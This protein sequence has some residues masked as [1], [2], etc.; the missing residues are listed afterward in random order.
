MRG[1]NTFV[2]SN[3]ARPTMMQG[4]TDFSKGTL[5]EEQ[6]GGD[7]FALFGA[8]FKEAETAGM[9]E[10][11][12]MALATAGTV[13]ISC[14]IVY[15]RGFDERGF[16][17]FTNYNSRKSMDIER[18]PHAALTFFWPGQERQVRIEGVAERVEEAESDAYFAGRPRESRIGAWSS[19]QSRPVASREQLDERFSRWQER[20]GEGDVPRPLHW[21]GIRVKPVRMEFWQG[22]SDRM[23][24][25]IVFERMSDG[26]W[27]RVRLQP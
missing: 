13:T 27:I 2:H 5:T 24:D 4:R 10:P 9:P 14:R 6:A 8:W 11:N 1:R 20:F 19:D 18:D 23:H 3:T 17:F 25:R 15:L 26:A 16:V 22:R 12:A 21:G 7:P